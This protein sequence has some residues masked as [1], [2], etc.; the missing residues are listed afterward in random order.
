MVEYDAL[1]LSHNELRNALRAAH[2][3]WRVWR[4]AKPVDKGLLEACVQVTKSGTRI[5][6]T[7][8]IRRLRVA[9]KE[10]RVTGRRLRILIGGEIK[11]SEM[12]TRYK[13]KGV[14]TWIPQLKEWLREQPYKFWLGTMQ[15]TLKD[16]SFLIHGVEAG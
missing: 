1:G 5:V 13:E 6:D 9:L 7:T 10:L 16:N 12:L 14:F 3:K 8:V 11:A 2:R 15:I 4:S